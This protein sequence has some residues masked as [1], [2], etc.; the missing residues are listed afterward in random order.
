[1]IVPIKTGTRPKFEFC[2]NHLVVND[3]LRDDVDVYS[4]GDVLSLKQKLPVDCFYGS[5]VF[6][7][8]KN[9]LFR[10]RQ[11]FLF[12][13][14]L[15]TGEERNINAVSRNQTWISASSHSDILFGAQR[16][17]EVMKFFVHS[18]DKHPKGELWYLS[19]EC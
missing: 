8:S 13:T 6:T 2:Q 17:F 1:M 10:V 14:D 7:C 5:R 16:F 3:G 18:F 9:F 15:V 11:G 19:V 12:R 4:I